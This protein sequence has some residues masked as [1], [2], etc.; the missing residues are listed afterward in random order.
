MRVPHGRAAVPIICPLI[1]RVAALYDFGVLAP[2]LL[3]D[4]AE[5][6]S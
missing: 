2:M 4:L 3:V 1:E 5:H 6:V